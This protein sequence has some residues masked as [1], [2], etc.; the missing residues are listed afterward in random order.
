MYVLSSFSD[1]DKVKLTTVN[2]IVKWYKSC[3]E[4]PP[5]PEV[6]ESGWIHP[7]MRCVYVC[8]VLKI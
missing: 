8:S 6:E 2:D 1:F 4:L 3:L 7:L 5:P